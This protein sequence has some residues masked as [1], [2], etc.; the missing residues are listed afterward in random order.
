VGAQNLVQVGCSSYLFG[1]K[2]SVVLVALFSCLL[3]TFPSDRYFVVEDGTLAV[4]NA[5]CLPAWL[6]V[7]ILEA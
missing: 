1:R 6:D 4:L 5:F 3:K 7:W 2:V